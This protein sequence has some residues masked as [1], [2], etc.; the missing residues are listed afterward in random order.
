MRSVFTWKC[1]KLLLQR[2]VLRILTQ[3]NKF[4]YSM[5]KMSCNEYRIVTEPPHWVTLSL[6]KNNYSTNEKSIALKSGTWEFL[7]NP[8]MLWDPTIK[9]ILINKLYSK[10]AQTPLIAMFSTY[11]FENFTSPR[12]I[13]NSETACFLKHEMFALD[14]VALELCLAWVWVL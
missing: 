10:N 11:L 1:K 5:K 2:T 13:W 9:I 6:P 12:G 3:K 7:L 8:L 14:S 4:A